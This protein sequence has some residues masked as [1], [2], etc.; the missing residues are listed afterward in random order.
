MPP[1]RNKGSNDL[2]IILSGPPPCGYLPC[3]TIVG[4]IVRSRS[5]LATDAVITLSLYGRSKT[6]IKKKGKRSLDSRQLVK[7]G[8][9]AIF[10]GA[11]HLA[12]GS[13]VTLSWPFAVGIPF[14]PS[15]CRTG[16]DCGVSLIPLDQEHP[17]HHLFPATFESLDPA[18]G[19][20]AMC[21]VEYY[22][23]AHLQSVSARC[24]ESCEAVHRIIIRHPLEPLF[25]TP[26]LKIFE[27]EG[28]IQSHRLMPGKEHT[29]L[30]FRQHMQAL[31]E[32]SKVPEFNFR[33]ILK[34]PV[35]I[36][37]DNPEPFQLTIEIQPQL[38][39]TSDILQDR[40]P[41]V[42]VTDIQMVLKQNTV[43]I[44][45]DLFGSSLT[46]AYWEL[47]ELGLSHAFWKQKSPITISTASEDPSLNIG[48]LFGL[49]IHRD[50]L[51]SN[52]VILN[53]GKDISPDFLTYN[54][55]R[56]HEVGWKV[57]ILVAGRAHEV[58][59]NSDI[60]IVAAPGR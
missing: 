60:R 47:V 2:K 36:Q 56:T 3:D 58:K 26:K 7:I 45:E 40:M 54:I 10:K 59:F 16:R 1:T 57:T 27:A 41:N 12:E 48:E 21:F 34:T 20:P 39:R 38:D 50:G 43:L 18:F 55:G 37:L 11:L 22:I 8:P 19:E 35:A 24:S 51:A 49:T 6:K 30:T 5:I 53:G 13:K 28:Q 14:E 29:K 15:T 23:T 46:H 33:I 4:N 32:S 17:G 9:R 25:T 31:L 42:V 44:G 52:G